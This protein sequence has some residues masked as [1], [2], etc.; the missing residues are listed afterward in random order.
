MADQPCVIGN[1]ITIRGN[2][3]GS[4][5]LVVEGRIEGT[6]ALSSHLTVDAAG[7]VEADVDVDSLTVHG[8]LLGDIRSARVVSISAGARVLGNVTA[9]SVVIEDGAHFKGRI[10]MDFD[11]PDGV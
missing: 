11:L 6:V 2:L 1:A 3:S 8:A 9:G 7:S 5:D 4:E 10:E